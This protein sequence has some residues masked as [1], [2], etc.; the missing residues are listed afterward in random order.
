MDGGK[1]VSRRR[2]M[3]VVIWGHHLHSH[4]HSYIHYG[5]ERAFKALGHDVYWLGDDDDVSGFD[6]S[7]SLFLTEWQVDDKIP[8]R[9][10]CK[11]VLHNC[12]RPGGFERYA[13]VADRCLNLKKFSKYEEDLPRGAEKIGPY[14]LFEPATNTLIQPWATDLLPDEIN[15]HDAGIGVESQGK[16]RCVFIGSYG[17]GEYGNRSEI[18]P[19]VDECKKLGMEFVLKGSVS[20]EENKSMIADGYIC[21]ALVGAWQARF[22]YIACRVFKNISYGKMGVT[23]SWE[24]HDLFE[25]KLVWNPDTRQLVH[26]AIPRLGDKKRIVELMKMVKERHTY[27]N[28]INTI[29]EVLP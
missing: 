5:F 3:K 29:M 7:N 15:F 2:K 19:F 21:P 10:D 22:G 26:D 16:K 13:P 9:K 8:I 1:R 12:D 6:F 11:Y 14:V 27:I 23:N 4:T 28:R 20:H 25:G 17:E 18:D 24:Q